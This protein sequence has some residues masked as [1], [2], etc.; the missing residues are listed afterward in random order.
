M[1]DPDDLTP[2]NTPLAKLLDDALQ[3][4]ANGRLPKI[5]A[6]SESRITRATAA[7]AAAAVINA[8]GERLY[9]LESDVRRLT[10]SE[11][12]SGRWRA[13]TE[14]RLAELEQWRRDTEC[15]PPPSEAAGAE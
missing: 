9:T 10:E 4:F 15:C 7:A 6:E 13:D 1:S 5:L 3:R 11:A 2:P 12:D 14:R 8:L